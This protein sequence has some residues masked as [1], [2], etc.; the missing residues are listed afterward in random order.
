MPG[1]LFDPKNIKI[2]ARIKRT[3]EPAISFRKRSIIYLFDKVN[4]KIRLQLYDSGYLT[5]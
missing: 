5:V 2:K 4:N 1:I 3:S